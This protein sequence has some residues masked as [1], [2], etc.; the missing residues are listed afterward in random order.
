[1]VRIIRNRKKSLICILAATFLL[2]GC[3]RAASGLGAEAVSGKTEK[4]ELESI[5][6]DTVQDKEA[7]QGNR[8]VQEIYEEITSEV[9]L[10]SP[11][12]MTEA[13]I[14]NYYGIDPQLLEEYVF[15]I[16]EEATSAETVVI[17]KVKDEED[18][19]EIREGLQVVLEEKRNEMENYLP[20]QF[21]I[22]DKSAVKTKG[23]YVYLVISDKE[24]EISRI[25]E[26]GI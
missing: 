8:A 14:A 3:G 9:A 2:T 24:E 13:F 23:S 4:T 16:S 25:I 12:T 6:M 18:I 1:M 15:S 22:V 17:M 5:E 7:A 19:E 10:C 20:S 11:M 26:S 21:E